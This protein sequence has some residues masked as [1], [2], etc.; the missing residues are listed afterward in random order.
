MTMHE[1]LTK[2][3]STHGQPLDGPRIFQEEIG[4]PNTDLGLDIRDLVNLN[5]GLHLFERS[6]LVF[7]RSLFDSICSVA[8]W[9]STDGW[10][11]LYEIDSS[12]IFFA[13]DVF[14]GQFCTDGKSIF[15]FDPESGQFDVMASSLDAWA[16]KMLEDPE[17]YSGS[18]I[19][20]EWEATVGSLQLTDRL[21]AK[22]P[23]IMGGSY[24]ISNLM[25]MDRS[26]AMKYHGEIYR[27]IKDLP[28]GSQVVFDVE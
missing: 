8:Q 17:F 24:S 1:N 12:M 28:D 14:S 23:F 22:Q 25:S 16:K 18:P 2:L 20:R 5:D 21:A 11:R 26:S 10:R 9:N 6:V 3:L 13:E 4:W 19:L 7:P 27:Q 15:K